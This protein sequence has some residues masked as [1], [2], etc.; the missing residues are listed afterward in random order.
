MKFRVLIKTP[1]GQ[2]TGTAH[3]ISPFIMG[4]RTK[5]S[6]TTNK[7]DDEIIWDVDGTPKDYI[8]I[9]RNVYLFDRIIGGILDHKLMKKT[10]RTKLRPE[11]EQELREMLQQH[12]S[13]TITK[14]EF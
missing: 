12:T 13:V 7:D 6:V 4:L 10:M 14:S 9:S 8:R 3:K 1:K 5:H 11:Q 2:A